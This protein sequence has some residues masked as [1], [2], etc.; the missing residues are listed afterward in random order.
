MTGIAISSTAIM[1]ESAASAR[2]GALP[3]IIGALGAAIA[4]NAFAPLFATASIPISVLGIV[5]GLRS[6]TLEAV[7]V[8]GLALICAMAALL[9]S[10][11][12]WAATLASGVSSGRLL[13]TT[14]RLASSSPRCEASMKDCRLV[15]LPEMITATFMNR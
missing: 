1:D 2:S 10:D 7:A 15:P 12:F 3:A 9:N 4:L 5:L 14:T 6:R 11:I 13:T 8:G